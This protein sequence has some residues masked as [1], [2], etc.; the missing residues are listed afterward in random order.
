MSPAT[1]T[2]A[3]SGIFVNPMGKV[4]GGFRAG[5]RLARITSTSRRRG[6]WRPVPEAGETDPQQRHSE[7]GREVHAMTNMRWSAE[8]RIVMEALTTS[9]ETVEI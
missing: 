8:Y 7:Y 4:R 1:G 9:A 2:I 3:R 6:K 5:R